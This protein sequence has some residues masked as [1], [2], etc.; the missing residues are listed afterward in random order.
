[1]SYRGG[2]LQRRSHRRGQKEGLPVAAKAVA[3]NQSST[4]AT[5]PAGLS[6]GNTIGNSA[7]VSSDVKSSATQKSYASG[8]V[9]SSVGTSSAT[10]TSTTQKSKASAEGVNCQPEKSGN[11]DG[12]P[13]RKRSPGRRKSPRTREASSER[14]SEKFN[15]WMARFLERM[16]QYQAIANV[17][18]EDLGQ[19]AIFS[20]SEDASSE[21]DNGRTGSKESSGGDRTEKILEKLQ[22]VLGESKELRAKHK[23]VLLENLSELRMMY[24]EMKQEKKNYVRDRNTYNRKPVVKKVPVLQDKP[25]ALDAKERL[26]HELVQAEIGTLAPYPLPLRLLLSHPDNAWQWEVDGKMQYAIPIGGCVP[27]SPLSSSANEEPSP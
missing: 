8:G 25:E 22:N 3:D 20:T 17:T 9:D 18:D 6:P 24:A 5:S 27:M 15:S 23:N 21:E 16:R 14:Q 7:V 1:M 13:R 19:K 11:G 2:Y 4:T 26:A 12:V 10:T